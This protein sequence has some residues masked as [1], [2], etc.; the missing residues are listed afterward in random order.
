MESL[1]GRRGRLRPGD[2]GRG[3]WAA[4]CK[5]M[6]LSVRPVWIWRA[7]AWDIA[8][9]K[10]APSAL[11]SV[12]GEAGVDGSRGGGR[13]PG[14]LARGFLRLGQSSA[15]ARMA[16]GGWRTARNMNSLPEA[17]CRSQRS[18]GTSPVRRHRLF[19]LGRTL[20]PG[21][22]L[23]AWRQPGDAVPRTTALQGACGTAREWFCSRGMDVRRQPW[24]GVEG[25]G[26]GPAERGDDRL[27]DL[28]STVWR[29]LFQPHRRVD[30][31]GRCH[32][33]RSSVGFCPIADG[34]GRGR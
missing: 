23:F 17:S 22:L 20:A 11:L 16:D 10:G 12:S 24:D 28:V 21:G 3:S 29:V 13:L 30:G 1:D 26:N 19:C 27:P 32:F 9:R 34:P 7:E 14:L 33:W 18:M 31:R 25:R 8:R 5:A 15:D 2:G 6:R 4:P